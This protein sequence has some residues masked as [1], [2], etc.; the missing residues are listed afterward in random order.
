MTNRIIV[1]I[2]VFS[3]VIGVIVIFRMNLDLE[4]DDWE[5]FDTS[6]DD[7]LDTSSF[8][9]SPATPVPPP[10]PSGSVTTHIIPDITPDPTPR[11]RTPRRESDSFLPTLDA[12]DRPPPWNPSPGV[13]PVGAPVPLHSPGPACHYGRSRRVPLPPLPHSHASV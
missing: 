5:I 9:I 4:V 3:I 7:A 13:E 12:T 6:L 10:F 11:S 8:P 2:L 1:I